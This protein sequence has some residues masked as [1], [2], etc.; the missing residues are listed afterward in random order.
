M[1][2]TRST[3]RSAQAS[4]TKGPCA[5]CGINVKVDEPHERCYKH[6]SCDVPP[7]P[8]EHSSNVKAN[9]IFV[10]VETKDKEGRIPDWETQCDS[11]IVG[12]YSTRA[13]AEKAK[14]KETR[15]MDSFDDDETFHCGECYN[16]SY[17]IHQE[18]VADT[19]SDDE[20]EDY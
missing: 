18:Y 9:A 13:L 10:L 15:H 11:M 5:I 8:E 3:K 14:K 6:K 19:C 16:T 7:Q 17:V 1:P 12:V 4:A 20:E 2:N